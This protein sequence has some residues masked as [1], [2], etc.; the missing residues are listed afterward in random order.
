[1]TSLK[2]LQLFK[3]KT[4]FKNIFISY[5]L[6]MLISV[7]FV[8]TISRLYSYNILLDEVRSTTIL[9]PRHT[10]S[11]IDQEIFALNR[12]ASQIQLNN[13]INSVLY[14]DTKDDS[15]Y[16][17][18]YMEI[19]K[20][21]GYIKFTQDLISNIWVCLVNSE[22]VIG[23]MGTYTADF[24]GKKHIINGKSTN[25]WN[26]PISKVPQFKLIGKYESNFAGYQSNG[27]SFM[28]ILP[29]IQS[30][31]P[32]GFLLLDVSA[33]AFSNMLDEINSERS[34][35]TFILDADNNVIIENGSSSLN[36]SMKQAI[37]YIQSLIENT[38]LK[39]GY[40][41]NFNFNG[42]KYSV[43]YNMLSTTGLN[44]QDP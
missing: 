34:V 36:I 32:N 10:Q 4:V 31:N 24:F 8:G 38:R 2:C 33:N 9:R 30:G 29:S 17:D 39:E 37:P 28:C 15:K 11:T 43:V 21:L 18:K 41:E 13:I 5:T 1:M 35:S 25:I 19:T 42:A 14:I 22:T 40:L 27:I 20:Q 23:D 12:I 16:V 6:L 26:M 3:R 7:V 44:R